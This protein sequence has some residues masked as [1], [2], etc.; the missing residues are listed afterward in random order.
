[1][2]KGPFGVSLDL[3]GW[4]SAT[5]DLDS[6]P[7]N[8]SGLAS[9]TVPAYGDL[10][11]IT[12][13]LINT[14]IFANL[15]GT[16]IDCYV[17]FSP[18]GGVASTA[19]VF[20]GSN[21]VATG[22]HLTGT[23][24]R[25]TASSAGVRLTPALVDGGQLWMV[26]DIPS[27]PNFSSI[28]L[29]GGQP[30]SGTRLLVT[31]EGN[32]LSFPDSP[33]IV[34]PH[35]TIGWPRW[36]RWWKP[37]PIAPPWGPGDPPPYLAAIGALSHIDLVAEN[38]PQ[39]RILSEKPGMFGFAHELIGEASLLGEEDRFS[40]VPPGTNEV[41]VAFP[42][43]PWANAPPINFRVEWE[44]P[45]P[46]GIVD[47]SLKVII[48]GDLNGWPNE[49]LGSLEMTRTPSNTV[50]LIADFSPVD[51]G[52]NL[53]TIYSGGLPVHTSVVSNG[54]PSGGALDWPIYFHGPFPLC[55]PRICDPS[56]F[57]LSLGWSSNVLIHLADGTDVFGDRIRFEGNPSPQPSFKF[58]DFSLLFGGGMSNLTII[59]ERTVPPGL[60]F[61][62]LGH[63][64][65]GA[66]TLTTVS[67]ELAVSNLVANTDFGASIA[68]GDGAGGDVTM[69]GPDDTSLDGSSISLRAF[70]TL[71][72]V[73][74]Q[75]LATLLATKVGTNI[76]YTPGL[77]PQGTVP[78]NISVFDGPRLVGVAVGTTN[79]V[80]IVPSKLRYAWLAGWAEIQQAFMR[81]YIHFP[82]RT[83]VHIPS[84]P[85]FYVPA[86]DIIID[87]CLT[88]ADPHPRPALKDVLAISRFDLIGS[89]LGS[90]RIIQDRLGKFGQPHSAIGQAQLQGFAGDLR[91]NNLVSG[92][93]NMDGLE[94]F[95][96]FTPQAVFGMYWRSFDQYG[97]VP[98]GAV[99]RANIEGALVVNGTP[100]IEQ[101]LASS[102]ITD[103][104]FTKE[105][106]ADFS[107]LNPGS[108]SV[109]V[110]SSN[111]LVFSNSVAGSAGVVAR[112]SDWGLG[113]GTG[114][115]GHVGPPPAPWWRFWP[116]VLFEIDNQFFAG[117]EIRFIPT[118]P[119]NAI[120]HVS[121]FSLQTFGI[122][123]LQ[124]SS[125]VLQPGP[126]QMQVQR[127]GDAVSI[128]WPY[129]T[130]QV[131][132]C[133]GSVKGPWVEV[134]GALGPVYVTPLAGTNRFYRVLQQQ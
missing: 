112:V 51:T 130:R 31:P 119:T 57:D 76:E 121:S 75:L 16:N 60:I 83:T 132:Q 52:S 110:L 115:P 114:V 126:I 8:L 45:F 86:T 87:Q 4:H 13:Q 91:V 128:I 64:P 105:I 77:P 122:E 95:G 131:F 62:G 34:T 27:P 74:E 116:T 68:L 90:F 29:S 118:Y 97:A 71:G 66:A 80:I 107:A 23:V 70:G 30:V 22:E 65:I 12:N 84:P 92:L 33:I 85:D 49:K 98:T 10:N 133:A 124:L 125:E 19:M 5:I 32:Q 99:A 21:L 61:N 93:G 102:Q 40:I 94:F 20:D 73:P 25:V 2:A 106:S 81:G 79:P 101:V 89:G 78:V 129:G 24:A 104:G 48:N 88:C 35:V 42:L 63:L 54:I 111:A 69:I 67:N 82:E 56:P 41:G 9:V 72:G 38:V 37:G 36:W 120:D 26:L 58:E 59:N 109:L 134:P 113:C 44:H 7:P 127:F 47:S 103:L 53:V 28:T 117:D 6:L 39:L 14:V 43:H 50:A 100:G 108:M 123:D 55:D 46:Q 96:L 11:G 17:D 3:T 15:D 1:M 18:I